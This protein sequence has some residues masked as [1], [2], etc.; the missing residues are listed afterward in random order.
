MT[1]ARPYIPNLSFAALIAV[2]NLFLFFKYPD[3]NYYTVPVL[4]IAKLYCNTLLVLFNSRMRIV[5]GREEL[6][7]QGTNTTSELL[8]SHPQFIA[9]SRPPSAYLHDMSAQRKTTPQT[10]AFAETEL[11]VDVGRGV[12]MAQDDLPKHEV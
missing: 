7:N 8:N 12:Y 11:R 10:G 6:L 5:G 4:I 3:T 9:F 1:G 2:T